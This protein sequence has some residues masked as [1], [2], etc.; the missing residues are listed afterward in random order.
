MDKPLE[1]RIR[2]SIVGFTLVFAALAAVFALLGGL[3]GIWGLVGV[4]GFFICL[5][6]IAWQ[7]RQKTV[8]V[9]RLIDFEERNR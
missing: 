8:D 5:Y 1:I 9:I 2:N 7:S 3:F 4:I 6:V